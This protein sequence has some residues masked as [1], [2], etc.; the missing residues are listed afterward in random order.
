MSN[1]LYLNNF[2]D[3]LIS[4]QVM[5]KADSWGRPWYALVPTLVIGGGLAYLNVSNSGATVFGWFS[6]LTSLFTLFGWGMICLS[7]IR[8]RHAWKIQG[9]RVEDLPWRTWTWPWGAYWGLFWCIVLIIAEFYLAVWPLG[10]PTTAQ[11]F[12]S[13]YVSVPA[14][15]VLYIGAK[16][17]FRGRRWVDTAAIDLDTGRRFYRDEEIEYAEA[18]NKSWIMRGVEGIW[19]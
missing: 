14:I 15:I 16:I 6:N 11:G 8:M 2:V 5:G 10:A 18:K 7:H 19:T 12:F 3:I 9:R 17:Y 4:F 1:V 13:V